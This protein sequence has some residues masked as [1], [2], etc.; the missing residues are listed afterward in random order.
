MALIFGFG[1][2]ISPLL[3][4]PMNFKGESYFL[5]LPHRAPS[6]VHSFSLLLSK[7]DHFKDWPLTEARSF[8]A[9]RLP[10]EALLLELWGSQC[11]VVCWLK[12]V[13]MSSWSSSS[14]IV[15][16]PKHRALHSRRS[17]EKEG[18]NTAGDFFFPLIL[19]FSVWKVEN[20]VE[21]QIK[22]NE[23]ACLPLKRKKI[24]WH[25]YFHH[26]YFGCHP[27]IGELL[28]QLSF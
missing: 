2:I 23:N 17:Q 26:H 20:E 1:G 27:S 16:T 18:R 14:H 5:H 15:N 24:P 4:Y 13:R 25:D 21:T 8:R 19:F 10:S 11:S 6:G 12:T 22:Q 7:S 3:A 9:M 28:Q